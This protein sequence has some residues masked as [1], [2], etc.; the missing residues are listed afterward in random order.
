[1]TALLDGFGLIQERVE[2]AA[3]VF[4]G[5]E[6]GLGFADIELDLVAGLAEVALKALAFLAGGLVGGEFTGEGGFLV[7][8]LLKLV[9][10][11]GDRLLIVQ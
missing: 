9:M 1:M 11:G 3:L 10:I 6:L 2:V 8:P 5:G 7:A 4:D